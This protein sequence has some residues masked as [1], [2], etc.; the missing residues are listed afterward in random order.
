VFGRGVNLAARLC[1]AAGKG[2]VLVAPSTW[3]YVKHLFTGEELD[4]MKLKGM[5]DP[6]KPWKITGLK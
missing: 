4:E 1:S 5:A 2:D 3:D 6:V